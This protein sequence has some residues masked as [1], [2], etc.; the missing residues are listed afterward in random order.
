MPNDLSLMVSVVNFLSVK[1][2]R[3]ILLSL[4]FCLS[5]S[6]N[7]QEDLNLYRKVSRANRATQLSGILSG[8]PLMYSKTR[9]ERP[10]SAP[11][12]RL[13]NIQGTTIGSIWKAYS[14]TPEDVQKLK[15]GKA[16]C[17]AI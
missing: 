7:V 4:R 10:K 3:A 13:K 12:L 9:R 15:Q 1:Q 2:L 6:E 16:Q 14:Q 17:C 11:Y 8:K 5:V